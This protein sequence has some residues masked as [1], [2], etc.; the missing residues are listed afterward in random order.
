MSDKERFRNAEKFSIRCP[1]CAEHTEFGSM[2]DSVRY[3]LKYFIILTSEQTNS[4]QTRGIICQ[5]CSNTLPPGS[6]NIQLEMQLR[7][8]IA[9]YYDA[10][11]VCNDQSC[12]NK[13]RMMS[14][15]GKRCLMSN[16]L[17]VM[18]HEVSC[19]LLNVIRSNISAV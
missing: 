6:V 9:K 13:T 10:N 2:L 1:G 15:Y 3:F 8:F 14:V 18:K 12:G 7:Q 19:C 4:V 5:S 17:G 11:L 16:C